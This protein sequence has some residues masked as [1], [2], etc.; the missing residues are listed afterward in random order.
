MRREA[1]VNQGKLIDA[2]VR[3]AYAAHVL[4]TNL[5]F[6]PEEVQAQ[7]RNVVNGDPPGPHVCVVLQRG[8]RTFV[9]H[10]HPADEEFGKAFEK[11]WLAFAA[12]K[13]SK[14]HAELQRIVEG[15]QLWQQKEALLWGLVRKG[16]E[17]EPGK[18]VH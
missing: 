16:F 7:I 17:L 11:A 3:E 5:G 9:I 12:A 13:P 6:E 4:I 14:P 10:L 1:V 8:E 18:M 15:T 2:L